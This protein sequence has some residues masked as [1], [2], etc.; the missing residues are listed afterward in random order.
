MLERE[1]LE[2]DQRN[3]GEVAERAD[4]Q[5]Q[6]HSGNDAIERNGSRDPRVVNRVDHVESTV[7]ALTPGAP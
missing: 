1:V 5:E 2:P 6:R 3:D 4:E 7:H